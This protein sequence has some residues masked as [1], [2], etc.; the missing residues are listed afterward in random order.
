MKSMFTR[1]TEYE[2]KLVKDIEGGVH[3]ANKAERESKLNEAYLNEH[4][5]VDESAFP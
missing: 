4:K 5:D 2:T 1:P 3:D